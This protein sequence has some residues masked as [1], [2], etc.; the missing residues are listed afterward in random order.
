MPIWSVNLNGDAHDILESIPKGQKSKF[1]R[2][3]IEWYGKDNRQINESLE[4]HEKLREVFTQK[5]IQIQEFE[6]SFIYKIFKLFNK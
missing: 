3:A 4:D 2:R 6:S 5:C 1:V